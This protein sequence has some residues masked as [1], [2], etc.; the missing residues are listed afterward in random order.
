MSFSW[1]SI[2]FII[3][4]S[5]RVFPRICASVSCL[6]DDGRRRSGDRD[7]DPCGDAPR[8]SLD[9]GSGLPRR[10][11]GAVVEPVPSRSAVGRLAPPNRSPLLPPAPNRSTGAT[12]AWGGGVAIAIASRI[13]SS[14]SDMCAIES[15]DAAEVTLFS[16][17]PRMVCSRSCINKSRSW[18]VKKNVWSV[19]SLGLGLVF[20]HGNSFLPC[21]LRTWVSSLTMKPFSNLSRCFPAMSSS[22]VCSVSPLSFKKPVWQ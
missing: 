3:A 12:A 4:I 18:A 10:S 9:S 13:S 22:C 15:I 16:V 6:R 7:G 14:S 20:S 21:L 8:R 1:A 17:S 2:S 5:S 19:E 11:T